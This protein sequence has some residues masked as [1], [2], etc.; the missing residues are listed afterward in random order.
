MMRS[1]CAV[2]P[3]LLLV[4]QARPQVGELHDYPELMQ[5][6]DLVAIAECQNATDTG[7]RHGHP[8]AAFGVPVQEWLATFRIAVV[9][10]RHP[11]TGVGSTIQFSYLRLDQA[12]W[13]REHPGAGIINGGAYVAVKPQQTY[14]LFLKARGVGVYEPVTG[15]LFPNDSVYLLDRNSA[16][17]NY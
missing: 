8:D 4:S 17:G 16:I 14:L 9:L 11:T 7:G 3:V 6:A 15:H 10:K 5:K 2:G 13:D 12:R 1:G